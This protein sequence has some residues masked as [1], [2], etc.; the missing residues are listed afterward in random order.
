MIHAVRRPLGA[1]YKVC[2][3]YF[4]KNKRSPRPMAEDL[5]DQFVPANK[6][7]PQ[8]NAAYFS[9]ESQ[10]SKSTASPCFNYSLNAADSCYLSCLLWSISSEGRRSFWLLEME[11][12]LYSMDLCQRRKPC[13]LWSCVCVSSV[14]LAWRQRLRHRPGPTFG[15]QREVLADEREKMECT[16]GEKVI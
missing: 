5:Y 10:G 11:A 1:F 15:G 16:R 6:K 2:L 13:F 8:I 12:A 14:G 9:H 7:K 3:F 4:S